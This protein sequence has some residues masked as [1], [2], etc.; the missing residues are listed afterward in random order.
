MLEEWTSRLYFYNSAL[1]FT[2]R[3]IIIS[4]SHIHER[5]HFE[6]T[7]VTT[8]DVGIEPTTTRLKVERSSDWANRVAIHTLDLLEYIVL[9]LT[10]YGSP[11]YT[12]AYP[13]HTMVIKV[14]V[15]WL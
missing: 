2:P 14:G 8:P 15:E 3:D 7:K 6:S 1:L 9:T 10:L 13:P 4:S 5:F 11:S 12:H